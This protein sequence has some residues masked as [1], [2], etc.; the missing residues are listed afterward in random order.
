MRRLILSCATL[1]ALSFGGAALAA[2]PQSQAYGGNGAPAEIQLPVCD[3]THT[4][5]CI[6]FGQNAQLDR[7]LNQS[8]PQCARVGGIAEK[9]ACF[10][11]AAGS[12]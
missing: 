10:N 8:Y 7:Q 6:E 11:R 2:S 3:R 4:D 9:A 12:G 1:A 5:H